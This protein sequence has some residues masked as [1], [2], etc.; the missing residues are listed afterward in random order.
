MKWKN[1]KDELPP[2]DCWVLVQSDWGKISMARFFYQYNWQ[3]PHNF[4]AR[5][6]LSCYECLTD[7]TH[8]FEGRPVA[9]IR[10]DEIEKYQEGRP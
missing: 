7:R 2:S 3:D 10:F 5:F 9:W 1:V 4:N 8:N 6:Q